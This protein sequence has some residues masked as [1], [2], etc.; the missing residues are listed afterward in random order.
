[1]ADFHLRGAV[2]LDSPAYIE[3]QFERNALRE[4]L[5]RQWVLLLGPRQHGKSSALIRIQGR[6]LEAGFLCARVD[7]QAMPP[8]G[9]YED[10]VEWFTGRVA[11]ALDEP[12]PEGL[13]ASLGGDLVEWFRAVVPDGNQP[14]VILIDEASAIPDEAM[15]NTFYGQLRAIANEAAAVGRAALE[16]RLS[17]LFAGTFRPETLVDPLNSPFNVCERIDTDDLTLENARALATAVAGD[18][19]AGFLED[20]YGRIGG[21]PY[22]MQTVL[23]RM[24]DVDSD[25]DIPPVL[26]AALDDIATGAIEHLQNVFSPVLSDP[27]LAAIVGE[28]ALP[29]G[30]ALQ[31]A[32]HDFK[33]LQV[34]GVAHRSGRRFVVRN[35]L[36]R[37][38]IGSSP[39]LNTAAPVEGLSGGLLALDPEQFDHMESLT[40][41]ELAHSSYL[42]AVHAYRAG[43]FRLALAG[44]GATLEAILLDLFAD[45][46]L[47][48][49][50]VSS[51]RSAGVLNLTRRESADDAST[52]RLVTLVRLASQLPDLGRTAEISDVVRDWRNQIHP[53]AALANF[54][55]DP[56]LEPEARMSS[57]VVCAL[58]RDIRA[59]IADAAAATT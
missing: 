55:P 57:G 27:R 53:A 31:P 37:D 6:L 13:R 26:Q 44:F 12:V 48:A 20:V 10:L 19:L 42:G 38:F 21:Q 41:G 36:Y 4:L 16:G 18:R 51:A 28:I 56:D 59:R 30:A 34:L 39:Q 35:E 25:D 11:R 46:D 33:F 23:S 47:L 58:L 17:F 43:S 50:A 22:L 32:S 8:C 1:M 9:T 5:N 45:P 40:L 29:D 14:L 7:L 24:A 49:G 3:R 2:P 52:L 15:R 54:K